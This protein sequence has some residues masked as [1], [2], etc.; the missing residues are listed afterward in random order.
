MSGP[1]LEWV[2]AV[3]CL[4]ALLAAAVVMLVLARPGGR[5]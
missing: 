2:I 1:V 4:A 3:L 5:G